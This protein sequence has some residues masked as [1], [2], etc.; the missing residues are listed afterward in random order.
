[1]SI[2]PN[3]TELTNEYLRTLVSYNPGTGIFTRLVAVGNNTRIGDIAGWVTCNGYVALHVRN[4]RFLAHRLA[5]F[6]MNGEFPAEEVDHINGVRSDNR[7]LNLRLA[8]PSENMRNR[9]VMRNNKLGI[10]GVSYHKA[11]GKFMAQ[12]RVKGKVFYLG[13]HESPDAASAAYV[14]FIKANHGQFARI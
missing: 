5:F 12:A 14:A 9:S 6:Y 1:M 2:P 7:W 13:V 10:K 4:I 8:T 11:S 3:R